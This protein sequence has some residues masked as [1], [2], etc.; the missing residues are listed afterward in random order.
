MGAE[1]ALASLGFKTGEQFELD[2]KAA[3]AALAQARKAIKAL[4]RKRFNAINRELCGGY[5]NIAEYR[6]V[7]LSDVAAIEAAITERCRDAAFITGGPGIV[8]LI[9]G[10]PSWGDPPTEL[11]ES[12]GRLADADV[13]PDA[14]WPKQ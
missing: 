5:K 2:Q 7:L 12:I 11:C 14:R 1:M 3:T 8:L 9:S 6:R 13:M 4:D 10:G